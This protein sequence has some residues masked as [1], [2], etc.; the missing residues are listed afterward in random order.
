MKLSNYQIGLNAEI[1]TSNYLKNK[2]YSILKHRYKTIYGEI[3]LI[4]SK[5]DL[6]IFVSQFKSD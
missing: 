1:I 4:A 6:L 5:D 2:G 3:D